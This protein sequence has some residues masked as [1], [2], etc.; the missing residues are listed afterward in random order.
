M[1]KEVVNAV[2]IVVGLLMFLSVPKLWH[3]HPKEMS[4]AT[5]VAGLLLVAL[6]VWAQ[7]N[8]KGVLHADLGAE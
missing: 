8:S 1:S 5:K 7:L 4:V 6:G 2:L 3:T